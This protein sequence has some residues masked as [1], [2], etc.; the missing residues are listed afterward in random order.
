[1]RAVVRRSRRIVSAGRL[2]IRSIFIR[3]RRALVEITVA[4]PIVEELHRV[5]SVADV[6]HHGRPIWMRHAA[7]EGRRRREFVYQLEDGTVTRLI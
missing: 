1:M 3:I 7:K 6:A 4:T 2:L 5:M